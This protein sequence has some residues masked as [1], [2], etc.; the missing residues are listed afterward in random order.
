MPQAVNSPLAAKQA[1]ATTR[2]LPP[3]LPSESQSPYQALVTRAVLSRQIPQKPGAFSNQ[4]QETSSRSMVPSV[5]LQMLREMPNPVGQQCHLDLGRAGVAFMQS[6]AGDNLSLLLVAHRG[7]VQTPPQVVH[8]GAS[9]PGS[10]EMTVADFVRKA[11][12]ITEINRPSRPHVA[13]QEQLRAHH[14]LRTPGGHRRPPQTAPPQTSPART[15]RCRP[16]APPPR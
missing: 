12:K 5:H 13:H 11:S 16:R 14:G 8:A 15:L 7:N 1:S 2:R 6:V 9:F 10:H 3:P 4:F